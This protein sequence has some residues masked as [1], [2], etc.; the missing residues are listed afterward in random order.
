[1]PNAVNETLGQARA[2]LT[3]KSKVP[4]QLY[5]E[6]IEAAVVAL[7]L[8]EPCTILTDKFQADGVTSSI[9]QLS[10]IKCVRGKFVFNVDTN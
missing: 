6:E 5:E 8:L 3:K 9:V 4:A 10:V 1:M 7:D 2:E